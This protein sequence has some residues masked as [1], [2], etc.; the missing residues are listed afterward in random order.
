VTFQSK[1]NQAPTPYSQ[2]LSSRL[3]FQVQELVLK[4]KKK[5]EMLIT[6]QS[7][8]K[9]ST[10]SILTIPEFQTVIPSPGAGS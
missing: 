8:E 4:E 9:P 3:K 7:K 10:S 6:F 1:E 5:K 2:F